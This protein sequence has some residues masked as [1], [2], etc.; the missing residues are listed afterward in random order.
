MLWMA[1]PYFSMCRGIWIPA[2]IAWET[3]TGELAR[4]EGE[5]RASYEQ[6]LEGSKGLLMQLMDGRTL[7]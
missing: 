7:D 6:A 4:F 2:V 1:A 5:D 3:R